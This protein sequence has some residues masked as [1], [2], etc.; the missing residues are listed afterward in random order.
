MAGYSQGK[1]KAET[2]PWLHH[3]FNLGLVMGSKQINSD[4]K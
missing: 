2:L 1:I 3:G 4:D